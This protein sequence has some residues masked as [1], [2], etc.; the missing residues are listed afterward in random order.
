MSIKIYVEGGGNSK[1]LKTACRKGFRLF[2]EKAG[3]AGRMPGI[4]ACGGRQN[5]YERFSMTLAAANDTPVLLVDAEAP[6][7]EATRW[8]HLRA[9]DAWERPNGAT[10][11][12]CHLMVQ[13]MESWFL[14]DRRALAAFYGGGF[15]GGALPGNP[16]VEHVPKSDVLS[17]LERATRTTQKGSYSKG[18]HG[19]EILADLDPATVE[20]AAPHARALLD[21][22]RTG[23]LP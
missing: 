3:L 23:E 18:S 19:F 16:H 14:A 1:A 2:F 6:V 12:Q 4:V 9:Q 15:Q 8:A 22:L 7:T 11:E 17:G 21:T 5:T 20:D 13:I 10:E